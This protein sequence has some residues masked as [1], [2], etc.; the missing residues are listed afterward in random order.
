[1]SNTSDLEMMAA[2]CCWWL[3]RYRHSHGAECKCELCIGSHGVV[4]VGH[5]GRELLD[6]VKV[7]LSATDAAVEV[8]KRDGI[9]GVAGIMKRYADEVREMVGE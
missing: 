6:R 4:D 8:L 2:V 1:M 5:P 9:H 7:L 3:L